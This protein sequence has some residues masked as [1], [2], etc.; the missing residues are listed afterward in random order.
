MEN[1]TKNGS[2]KRGCINGGSV[3]STTVNDNK[4]THVDENSSNGASNSINYDYCPG[5][6]NNNHIKLTKYNAYVTKEEK[7]EEVNLKKSEID[8]K[9]EYTECTSTIEKPKNLFSSDEDKEG[10]KS[11]TKNNYIDECRTDRYNNN[12]NGKCNDDVDSFDRIVRIH[13]S[14]S[15]GKRYRRSISST[16]CI[17]Y[18]A[19]KKESYTYERYIRLI[20]LY[21]LSDKRDMRAF[22][23]A[24]VAMHPN[25]IGNHLVSGASGIDSVSGVNDIG[26]NDYGINNGPSTQLHARGMN[27]DR[28]NI[29]QTYYKPLIVDSSINKLLCFAKNRILLI[30]FQFINYIDLESDK[31]KNFFLS[32]ELRTIRCIENINGNKFILADDYGDL[33]ILTCLCKSEPT[34]YRLTNENYKDTCRN[35]NSINLQFIGTCSRSNVIVSIFS[36]IIFLGSQVSDSYLLRMHNYPIY[37]CED[38]APVESSSYFTLN[39][40]NLLPNEKYSGHIIADTSNEINSKDSFYPFHHEGRGGEMC[41]VGG[42]PGYTDSHVEKDED[43]YVGEDEEQDKCASNSMYVANFN[44]IRNTCYHED[45]PSESRMVGADLFRNTQDN[46]NDGINCAN[47]FG[48]TSIKCHSRDVGMQANY[49]YRNVNAEKTNTRRFNHCCFEDNNYNMKGNQN[50]VGMTSDK[51]DFYNLWHTKEGLMIENKAQ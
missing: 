51:H 15:K 29:L 2:N 8:V 6:K 39:N 50:D 32:S 23:G 28:P 30:G 35:I 34:S 4:K 1:M 43:V 22:S 47:I 31:D 12:N 40:S 44:N 17:L 38:Y 49:S 7:K 24:Y 27:E 10:D 9:K 42:V 45:N 14:H 46:I 11:F 21:S 13:D 16:I 41:T 19:K 26:S 25:K 36:D 18:D 48:R 33:Y 20:P 3:S 5:D 37:E